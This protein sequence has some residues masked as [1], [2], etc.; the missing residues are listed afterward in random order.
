MAKSPHPGKR[1]RL[2]FGL[3]GLS[4]CETREITWKEFCQ[5]LRNPPRGS[6]TLADYLRLDRDTQNRLKAEP[7]WVVGGPC[8][9][10][11]RSRETIVERHLLTL[12]IDA[13]HWSILADLIDD[14]SPIC[15]Y[16]WVLHTTR[17]H[18]PDKPRWRLYLPLKNPISREI[19]E[20]VSRIVSS[21]IDSTMDAIDPVSFRCPQLMF[22]PTLC[23]DSEYVLHHNAG[24]LL[25]SDQ[26]L[27]DFGADWR[28]YS[29][30]PFSA[31]RQQAYRRADKSEDPLSKRG[32]IGAFCRAFSVDEVIEKFIPDVYSP[33]DDSGAHPR[34]TYADGEGANGAILY[35]DGLFLY[36]NHASDPAGGRN[37]NAF[38]L[39][40]IHK[41]GELDAG[42]DTAKVSPQ[43]WPSYK[44]AAE[45]CREQQSVESELQKDQQEIIDEFDDDPDQLYHDDIKEL[46]GEP[47]SGSSIENPAGVDYIQELNGGYAT[48]W[49]GGTAKKYRVVK[50]PKDGE[51]YS[52]YTVED[53]KK[54]K[55]EMGKVKSDYK[56]D[57]WIESVNRRHFERG[58]V[59]D[60]SGEHH[61]ESFNLWSGFRLEPEPGPPFERILSHIY[62]TL[63]AG[64]ESYGD[65]LIDWIAHLIQRPAQK[66]SVAVVL[67]SDVEGVGKDTLGKIV[68]RLI[69]DKWCRKVIHHAHLTNRFNE[70]MDRALLVQATEANFAPDKNAD[71]I[72]KGYISETEI[73]IEK[74]GIDAVEVPNYTRFLI[75]S[76]KEWVVRASDTSRRYFTL[77]IRPAF[78]PGSQRLRDYFN[79]LHEEIDDDRAMA[80][81]MHFL[82]KKT[83]RPNMLDCPITEAMYEQRTLSRGPIADWWDYILESGRI[84]RAETFTED[85][86]WDDTKV[87]VPVQ[88]L[89]D[90]YV[91]W[92]KTRKY[93]G[94]PVNFRQFGKDFTRCCPGAGKSEVVKVEGTTRRCRVIPSRAKCWA[95]LASIRQFRLQEHVTG[96]DQ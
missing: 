7:G 35:D 76:N 5:Q 33:G 67:R 52:L 21:F 80:S 83:L 85:S 93:Q 14:L 81:F 15:Q 59:F 54:S 71:D 94:D 19:H 16:E 26:I 20:P 2:A 73:T 36:S 31:E 58:L 88:A 51:D 70:F 47:P 30:L 12:D 79:D 61:P 34:Y 24:D 96:I 41:F 1:L 18:T 27:R 55:L 28:D 17:K 13:G 44:A 9:T 64:N 37:A 95:D 62:D 49:V 77:D 23:Q 25:D 91:D 68:R 4:R 11:T 46:F 78:E 38:D 75:T 45:W 74:K 90:S 8:L 86:S 42:T 10:G 69:G 3:H 82:S 53:F 72:L 6:E 43:N 63:C 60:P 32:V 65:Y 57:R 40:R 22:L 87:Q 29:T 84:P 89:Y 39:V 92:L 56:V 50:L 66:L 48:I